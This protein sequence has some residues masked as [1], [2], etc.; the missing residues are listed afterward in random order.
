MALKRWS[1]YQLIVRIGT[2]ASVMLCVPMGVYLM[3]TVLS[4]SERS[5]ADRGRMLARTLAAQITDHLLVSDR[6]AMHDALHK[7]ALADSEIR[8]LCVVDSHGEVLAHTF[9]DGYPYA[10][11]EIWERGSAQLTRFRTRN[12]PLMNIPVPIM[13]GSLGKVHVGMSRADAIRSAHRMMAPM[14]L[15]LAGAL[16]FVLVG[17]QVVAANVSRPLRR[18]DAQVSGYPQHAL[19]PDGPA[20]SG[21]KEV[22]SLAAGFADMAG[23]LESLEREREITRQR[24]Q[25]AEQLAALGQLAAGLA[26]EIHNPLDGML[27]CVRY[28]EAD[29]AKAE[30]A[31]KYLPMVTE[32]LERIA[33]V[34]K[35]ML[36]LARSGHDTAIEMCLAAE[37]S[38]SLSVIL[39]GHLGA[40]KVKLTWRKNGPGVCLCNRN[41]LSQ[42]ILNLVLNAAEAA[43]GH[44]D[45]EVIIDVND[46]LP[47]VSLT[48][49]DCGP[50]VPDD[51][52]E[53]I[54]EPFFTTKPAGTGTGLGLAISRQLI[55]AA[56]GDLELMPKASALGGACFR[57]RLPVATEESVDG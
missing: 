57:I 46:E 15:A 19:L 29:P 54:F 36:A 56:G 10:L 53:R 22:R 42:A 25:H 31:A 1:L 20:L 33:E 4:S 32:G 30:R 5:L 24:M 3:V 34:M 16:C 47:W 49:S 37:I 14:W 7:V 35:Q 55:R 21:T 23:R 44:D 28:M 8:Y 26:H 27:E 2:I 39:E 38:D 40:R 43:E 12:A 50:G 18:L 13:M 41:G 48:V 52:R 17:A 9:D 45:P 51:L 11:T 6:L